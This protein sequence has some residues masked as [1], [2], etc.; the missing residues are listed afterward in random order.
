MFGIGLDAAFIIFGEFVRT[1]ATKDSVERIGDTFEE[2]GLSIF[3]TTLTTTLAFALAYFGNIPN[4]QWISLYAFPS[5]LI[6]FIYQITLFV[7]LIVLDERRIERKR[8]LQSEEEELRQQI[9][10]GRG[11]RLSTISE[12]QQ[13]QEQQRQDED[14]SCNDVE[15]P[16][17]YS[18]EDV[19]DGDNTEG[20]AESDETVKNC[21]FSSRVASNLSS[22][23]VRVEIKDDS[24]VEVA[25]EPS[26]SQD[27]SPEQAPGALQP[28]APSMQ[29][30]SGHST[31]ERLLHIHNHHHKPGPPASMMD[32]A[33]GWYAQR[34]L[35]P[36]V[37]GC[38]IVAFLGL[39]AVLAYSTS[40]FTQGF[41]LLELMPKG[42]YMIDFFNAMDTYA[43]TGWLIPSGKYWRL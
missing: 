21:N 37:K 26:G 8:K 28:R 13:P 35:R 5:V 16:T 29:D 18:E 33:M 3:C 27:L 11:D 25:S 24:T 40:Q 41:D 4:L 31:H 42:S 7:A 2:V 19:E 38:V 20:G 32:R 17:A 23:S 39:T 12:E 22:C 6:D 10:T 30:I 15:Q 14:A 1:D 9:S 36:A 43:S 34:L